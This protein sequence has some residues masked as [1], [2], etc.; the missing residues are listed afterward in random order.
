MNVTKSQKRKMAHSKN[1]Y[2]ENMKTQSNQ[3]IIEKIVIMYILPFL[4]GILVI[5]MMVMI[6]AGLAKAN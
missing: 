5:W 4:C 6:V 1:I 2:K 3:S